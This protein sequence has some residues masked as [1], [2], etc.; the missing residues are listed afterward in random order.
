MPG[1]DLCVIQ[2]EQG[3][4]DLQIEGHEDPLTSFPTRQCAWKAAKARAKKEGTE[5]FLL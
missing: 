2:N 3:Q 5:A 1:G 4:W